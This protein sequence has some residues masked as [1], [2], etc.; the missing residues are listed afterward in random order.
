MK[1]GLSLNTEK[2]PNDK[3]EMDKLNSKRLPKS[4]RWPFFNSHLKFFQYSVGENPNTIA[5]IA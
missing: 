2:K 5:Q 3:K 1:S 4:K